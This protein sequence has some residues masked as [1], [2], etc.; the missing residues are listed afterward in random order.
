LTL[1]CDHGDRLAIQ[2]D[3]TALAAAKAVAGATLAKADDTPEAAQ[4]RDLRRRLAELNTERR[5]AAH[6]TARP[7]EA[8]GAAVVIG[9]ANL[10]ALEQELSEGREWEQRLADRA[11]PLQKAT[12]EAE[13]RLA[14]LRQQWLGA[15]LEAARRDALARRTAAERAL[16]EAIG[17]P[18]AE[19][20]A[21]ESGFGL[22]YGPSMAKVFA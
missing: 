20:L 6:A 15:A 11:E 13:R 14:Y 17:G 8:I 19:L 21:A 16:I 7:Q 12:A 18:L 4:V 10:G 3:A 1:L 22:L 5:D 9:D 2:A